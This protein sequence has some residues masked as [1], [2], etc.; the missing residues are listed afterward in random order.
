MTECQ[1]IGTLL[2]PSVHVKLLNFIGFKIR[3][4]CI[5]H[6]ADIIVIMLDIINDVPVFTNMIS[7]S[8]TKFHLHDVSYKVFLKKLYLFLADVVGTIPL[9]AFP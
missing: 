7:E 3:N 6:I 9:T 8:F 1:M 2:F 4:V 5:I